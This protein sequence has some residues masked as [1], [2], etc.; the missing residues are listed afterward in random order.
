MNITGTVLAAVALG[1]MIYRLWDH[2]DNLKNFLHF[3]I[4]FFIITFI[5][6]ILAIIIS[7][8]NGLIWHTLLSMMDAKS[9]PLQA[10]RIVLL[11]QIGKYLPGNVVHF[12]GRA[13]LSTREGVPREI[14]VIA[15]FLDMFFSA[16]AAS[17]FG[18]I[19]LVF[20]IRIRMEFLTFLGNHL[21]SILYYV[22][23]LVLLIPLFI[24][25]S[26]TIGY[27][28]NKILSIIKRIPVYNYPHLLSAF[29]INMLIFIVNGF[30]LYNL[31]FLLMNEYPRE[32]LFLFIWGFAL[33][34][35]VGFI[36][37]GAP[38]GIGIREFVF[39]MIFRSSLGEPLTI[40]LAFFIRLIHILS[41]ITGFVGAYYLMKKPPV[42]EEIHND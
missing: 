34:W 30:I 24:L 40:A 33:S 39:M 14:A 23:P 32:N 6:L 8:L 35:V 20:D 27:F 15:T 41:E 21:D 7:L 42:F 31:A 1:Y 3:D 22:I 4:R 2:Y 16:A 12:V 28:R 10:I 11:S 18:L 38:G 29:V 13:V 26:L 5:A 9:N 17:V 25:L 36:I 19:G 37:P